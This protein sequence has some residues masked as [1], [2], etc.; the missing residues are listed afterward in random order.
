MSITICEMRPCDVDT[1]TA[2]EA[3]CFSQPWLRHDFEDILTNPDRCYLVALDQDTV[4]GGCMLTALGTEGDI[5]NVAVRAD[6]RRRGI[7][8]QLMTE[9]I[10]YGQSRGITA[11]TL[12]VREHNPAAIA[13]YETVGFHSVGIR[14]NFYTQPTDNAV[15]MWLYL[16]TN[17]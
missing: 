8:R 3:S 9:L 5:S 2:L 15:I 4:V 7:A 14:P 10:A 11:F 17:R 16:D 13:L 12:E 6:Y 1:V